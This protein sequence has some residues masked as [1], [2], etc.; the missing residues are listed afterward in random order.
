MLYNMLELIRNRNSENRLNIAR[1]AYLL[2]RVRPTNEHAPN[3]RE[4]L[5]RF[6]RFKKQM[7]AWIQDDTDSQQL[8][9]AIYLY[10]YSERERTDNND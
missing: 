9:T 2:A 7:Y 3:F 10:V 5:E 8:I 1:F 4:N 6:D